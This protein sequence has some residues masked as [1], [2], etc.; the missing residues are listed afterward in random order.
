MKSVVRIGEKRAILDTD[1][2]ICLYFAPRGLDPSDRNGS[3][4][5]L[6][7]TKGG[8]K[9]FYK[10]RWSLYQNIGDSIELLREKE[11]KEELEERVPRM[12]QETIERIKRFFP[13][14]MEETA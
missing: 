11:A 8:I 5:Y 13:D 1:K 4:I 10:Y 14:F 7:I 12:S 9:I 2:D 3:D 6:H